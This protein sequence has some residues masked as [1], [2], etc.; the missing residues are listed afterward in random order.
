M[1]REALQRRHSGTAAPF[2]REL[3]AAEALA[4]IMQK[5]VRVDV[6]RSDAQ[7]YVVSGVRS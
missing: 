7:M 5:S 3:P 2:P 4:R 1:G 6:T